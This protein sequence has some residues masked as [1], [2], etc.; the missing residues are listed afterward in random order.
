MSYYREICLSGSGGQGII[1]AGI[2]LAEAAILEGRYAL[3]TQS[4]G[5]EARG[6]ASRA[7]VI[8]SEEFVDYPHVQQPDV[9]LAMS[10]EAYDKYAPAVKPGGLVLVDA[11]FVRPSGA[12]GFRQVSLPLTDTARSKLGKEISANLVA[13]GALVRL[14]GLV[15]PE[16]LQ[17]AVAGRLGTTP[18]NLAAL[19]AGRE[20]AESVG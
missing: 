3:Q 8:I 13:L 17:Q 19:E 4:Y 5:P 11:T 15:Q 16:S 6:G 20:L 10:Q 12:A 1:L 18:A 14:T 9:L 7:E 2:L